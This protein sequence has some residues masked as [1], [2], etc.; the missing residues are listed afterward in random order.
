MMGWD[1]LPSQALRISH[2]SERETPV[3][4]DESQWTMGRRNKRRAGPFSP[5]RLSLPGNFHR[6]RET[7]EH[8]AGLE[9]VSA[10]PWHAKKLTY[11]EVLS[12]ILSPIW[13]SVKVYKDKML[14][15]A[16]HLLLFN[17]SLWFWQHLKTLK[18]L[19]WTNYNRLLNR[20]HITSRVKENSNKMAMDCELAGRVGWVF[21]N[22]K[23]LD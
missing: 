12:L 14:D 6:E 5:S 15:K 10:W 13:I 22:L 19:K 3:N 7:S 2:R 21:S 17:S 16:N 8:E 4:G 9:M 20:N 11:I 23:L 1:L 18:I